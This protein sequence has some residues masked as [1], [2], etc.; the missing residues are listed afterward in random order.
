MQSAD[1]SGGLVLEEKARSSG[2][3]AAREVLLARRTRLGAW[4]RTFR[5]SDR[6]R[7]VGGKA[8]RVAPKSCAWTADRSDGAAGLPAMIARGC[9]CAA[10]RAGAGGPP[11][12]NSQHIGNSKAASVPIIALFPRAWK[13]HSSTHLNAN[14]M[15]R[16]C[17]LA[18]AAKV[19]KGYHAGRSGSRTARPPMP[20][21]LEHGRVQNDVKS[22]KGL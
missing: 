6:S 11:T 19:L 18:T 15:N 22:C 10:I 1:R 20:A 5:R 4:L 16:V 3:P 2:G 13:T 8:C 12:I 7:G 21:P 17:R 14:C 9:A